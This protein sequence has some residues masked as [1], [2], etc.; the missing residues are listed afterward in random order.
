MEFCESGNSTL[1]SVNVDFFISWATS[2]FSWST[3]N[4]TVC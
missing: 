3:L 2:S 1:S 4:Y